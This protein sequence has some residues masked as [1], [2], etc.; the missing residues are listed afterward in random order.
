MRDLFTELMESLE[1]L[2][3][4]EN[5]TSKDRYTDFRQVFMGSDQGKRVYQEL[6]SWGGLFNSSVR[7]N[8]IDPLRVMMDAGQRNFATKLMAAVNIEPPEKPTK[9]AVRK[10]K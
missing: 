2:P 7:G 9:A 5:Y 3:S 6:L 10:I 1:E 4:T 8:P